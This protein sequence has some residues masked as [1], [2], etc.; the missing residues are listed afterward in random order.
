MNDKDSASLGEIFTV[1]RYTQE[2]IDKLYNELL[3]GKITATQF[4]TARLAFLPQCKA[5]RLSNLD[6]KFA[7]IVK[8][9][10]DISN[11]CYEQHPYIKTLPHS[12]CKSLN[13]SNYPLCFTEERFLLSC[14]P[15]GDRVAYV[16]FDAN[17]LKEAGM[18]D[19]TIWMRNN[20]LHE[21]NAHKLLIGD[22]LDLK[23]SETLK[24]LIK[25][26][27][28]KTLLYELSKETTNSS[29][30]IS[31]YLSQFNLNEAKTAWDNVCDCYQ[32]LELEDFAGIKAC[33]YIQE[34]IDE[35]IPNKYPNF[36]K[37]NL[38]DGFER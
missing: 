9:S 31:Y 15:Y 6:V 17:R 37:H 14:I 18:C 38:Y 34:H 3:E 28:P 32:K 12:I 22:V 2:A 8:S 24:H 16:S 25:V 35:I 13:P 36:D 10:D 30:R 20:G 7:R 4:E 33:K 29:L 19:E 26:S 21:Y 23:Y 11:K 1:P 27:D 5:V